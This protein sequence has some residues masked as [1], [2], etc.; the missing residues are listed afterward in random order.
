V[1][2][3][4]TEYSKGKGLSTFDALDVLADLFWASRR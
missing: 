1:T 4:Y 2:I 3:R